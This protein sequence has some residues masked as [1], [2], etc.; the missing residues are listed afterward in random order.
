MRVRAQDS[1]G[2]YTFGQDNQNF[3][4]NSP[5]AVAQLV[6]TGLKLFQGEWFLDTS[7]G[8]P[9]MTDVIGF[10]TQSLYDTAIQNQILNTQGVTGI[11]NYSSS[12]NME[13]RHL[14]ISCTILTAFGFA[15]IATGIPFI[16]PEG[17]YGVTPYGE[18]YGE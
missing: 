17:G 8:M 14:E 15:N 1:S 6:V 3:F 9:W 13:T 11:E 10:N 2:D 7:V 18:S 12:L 16:P 5:E 4:V